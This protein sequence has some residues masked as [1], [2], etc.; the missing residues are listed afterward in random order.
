MWRASTDRLCAA[1]SPRA[2]PMA[3]A[4]PRRRASCR[5]SRR[6]SPSR[7]RRADKPAPR[8]R[9]CGVRA[10]RRGSPA[11]SR[12]TKRWA[13]PPKW[14][15]RRARTGSARA[16]V[17]LLLLLYGAGMRIAEALS[18]TGA[19]FPFGE[20]LTVTGK[21]GK[22]RVVPILPILGEAVADYVRRSPWPLVPGKA[23]VPRRQGWAA[24]AG[25]GAESG[26]A[27][28]AGSRPAGDRH[29]ACAAA[30]LRHPSAGRWRG[31]AEPAGTTGPRQ[32][33]LD[34]NL[35]Q[36]GCRRRCSTPIATPTRAN[37][38]PE[39]RA[40]VAR[41][42]ARSQAARHIRSDRAPRCRSG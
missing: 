20:R 10:S 21:G 33:G 18:L 1:N 15:T 4:M 16:T 2:G 41:A 40:A 25:H 26:G 23:V 6:S 35:Y 36:G 31:S 8:R 29:S 38:A 7:A 3:S 12:P 34:A 24:V 5:R 11:R 9:A 17:P 14:R 13:S 22:Q 27:R 39:F 37:A 19:D 42:A 28:A 32:P 30:Q